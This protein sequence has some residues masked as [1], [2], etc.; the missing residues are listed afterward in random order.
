M[1]EETSITLAW[2]ASHE[3]IFAS[4]KNGRFDISQKIL[5]QPIHSYVLFGGPSFEMKLDFWEIQQALPPK[6]LKMSMKMDYK[7]LTIGLPLKVG[8]HVP[9]IPRTKT[10]P[11]QAL[12][13]TLSN[14]LQIFISLLSCKQFSEP[15]KELT[16]EQWFV[17]PFGAAWPEPVKW[18]DSKMRG[19]GGEASRK[20]AEFTPFTLADHSVTVAFIDWH[21]QENVLS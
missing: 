14:S 19:I 18:E 12:S 10:P 17:S 13:I 1:L 3:S 15:L 21:P 7:S 11:L 20:I 2:N 4:A 9:V 8:R 6:S 16:T 5:A